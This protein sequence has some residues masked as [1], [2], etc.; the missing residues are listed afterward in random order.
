M[1]LFL[2]KLECE[3]IDA[4]GNFVKPTISP[5]SHRIDRGDQIP[6]SIEFRPFCHFILFHVA[7]ETT[8]FLGA[9]SE[10]EQDEYRRLKTRFAGPQWRGGR[11]RGSDLFQQELSAVRVFVMKGDGRDI[12]RG[13]A[14]G[15][16][17]VREGVIVNPSRFSVMISKSKSSVNGGF[18]A[19][20][21]VSLAVREATSDEI[22]R[23]LRLEPQAVRHWTLR[24][25]VNECP[26]AGN[27]PIE[28]ATTSGDSSI[29]DA[30]TEPNEWPWDGPYGIYQD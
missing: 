21:Y 22:L 30:S 24:C 7:M 19:L 13:L 12:T 3:W 2:R 8:K 5:F 15:I 11:N 14:C 20:G 9:M 23:A 18:Q 6:S 10:P 27:A 29:D 26:Q 16:Y 25:L 4:V 17:W 28:S 1:K